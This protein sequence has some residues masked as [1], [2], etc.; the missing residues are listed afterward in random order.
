MLD[1]T[2]PFYPILPSLALVEPSEPKGGGCFRL[3]LRQLAK[4]RK[5]EE[6]SL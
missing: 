6:L 3:G 4:T 1:I 5:D 2:H